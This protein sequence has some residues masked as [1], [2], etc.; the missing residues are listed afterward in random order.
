VSREAVRHADI[1]IAIVGFCYGTP[2][3]DMPDVS[4]TELEFE[5][6]STVGM[7]R[8]LF[9]LGQD[10]VGPAELFISPRYADRQAAFR[11]RLPDSG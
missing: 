8:L 5:E 9:L 6:A 4:Y 3:R 2:V 10:T 11:A 7:P 1:Y